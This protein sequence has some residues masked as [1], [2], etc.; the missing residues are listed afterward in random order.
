[1]LPRSVAVA[2]MTWPSMD[3]GWV[4]ADRGDGTRVLLTTTDAGSRWTPTG[5]AD[6]TGALQVLFADTT[7]GWIVGDNG[8]LSTHD[9]GATWSPVSILGGIAEGAAVAGAAG[10]VHV[11]YMGGNASRPGVRIATSPTDH[12][13]FVPAA[14][15][16]ASGAGPLLDVSMSAGGPYGE[17]TYNDRT[18][19]GAAQIRDGQWSTWDLTCPYANPQATAGLSPNGQALTIACGP[20]GFGDDAP[21]V[22][23]DLSSGTLAW[24]TVQPAAPSQGESRLD[25]AAATDNGVRVVVFTK[26]DGRAEI[27]SSTDKGATWPTRNPL[28]DGTTPSAI[29][30]LPD[31]SLLIATAPS[32]G[33]ISPDG[34]SWRPVA[35]SPG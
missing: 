6:L 8:V 26:T 17:M 25:F 16:I 30:H 28:P 10:T 24:T 27:A 33:L 3:R 2:S 35:T 19:I 9:G 18:L 4:L 11:A 15:N 12:D 1:M 7:N 22:G 29:A 32:S 31:G 13:A 14:V 34:L 21:I 20:S 5:P 23:A